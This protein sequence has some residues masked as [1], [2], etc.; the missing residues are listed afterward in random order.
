MKSWCKWNSGLSVKRSFYFLLVLIL[1]GCKSASDK[2]ASGSIQK[3]ILDSSQSKL[4]TACFGRTAMPSLLRTGS[5][6]RI[7][8]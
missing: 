3:I 4:L 5:S 8:P 2:D 7:R 6:Y 1:S